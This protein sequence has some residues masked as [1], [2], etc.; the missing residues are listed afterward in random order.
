MTSYAI[1]I[2]DDEA[3]ARNGLKLALKK[4]NYDVAAFETAEAALKAI[5]E[6]PP[7]LVLL[8]IGLPGMSGV[9]ALE[10][11][12]TQHPEVIVVMI[13]AYEDVPTVVSSM[14]NGA[15]EYDRACTKNASKK[16]CPALS[17]TAM[18]FRTSCSWWTKPPRARTRRF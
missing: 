6:R 10:I 14:K 11:I 8:D 9:K 2:V 15:Y 13:T 1:Y 12:K 17:V 3:V 16:T 7:D 4:K 18:P 5:D